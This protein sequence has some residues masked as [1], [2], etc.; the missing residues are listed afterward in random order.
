MHT[1]LGGADIPVN[2]CTDVQCH[3]DLKRWFNRHKRLA[4]EASDSCN[5]FL[6]RRARICRQSAVAPSW[7]GNRKR[8]DQ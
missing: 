1:A 6:R 3:D 4:A 5:R 2:H 7:I 8:T